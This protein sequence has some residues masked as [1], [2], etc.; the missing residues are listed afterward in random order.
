MILTRG[1]RCLQIILLS[2]AC[3]LCARAAL[4]CIFWN[5]CRNFENPCDICVE[6]VNEIDFV[7]DEP[8]ND[9]C[10]DSIDIRDGT[11]IKKELL[12][13]KYFLKMDSEKNFDVNDF[14]DKIQMDY[15]KPKDCDSNFEIDEP[16]VTKGFC[17]ELTWYE[18]TKDCID[19]Q[20]IVL[21]SKIDSVSTGNKN[22][23]KKFDCLICPSKL[24][25]IKNLKRLVETVHEKK[26]P[27][28]C[29]ICP[30][31]FA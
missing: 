13:I 5:F 7:F 30:S 10:L 18:L 17:R 8:L 24:A 4:H 3:L 27:F 12:K 22:R 28:Q 9:V 16:S 20:P 25:L 26:K 23:D 6:I 29:S 1:P 19:L 14:D 15:Q 11:E 2:P 31:K 21:P